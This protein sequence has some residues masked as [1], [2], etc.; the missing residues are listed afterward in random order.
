M[1][2]SHF[3]TFLFIFSIIGGAFVHIDTYASSED[4]LL[5]KLT[6]EDII[7]EA[8]G[9]FSADIDVEYSRTGQTL[10]S[11]YHIDTVIQA[12][13]IKSDDTGKIALNPRDSTEADKEDFG[14][15]QL[16]GDKAYL[17][18]STTDTEYAKLNILDNFAVENYQYLLLENAMS[19]SS[20]AITVKVSFANSLTADIS[21]A[22]QTNNVTL[23]STIYAIRQTLWWNL[24]E[25]TTS[26]YPYVINI[27]ITQVDLYGYYIF[28]FENNR[29]VIDTRY[30]ILYLD[31]DDTPITTLSESINTV[32]H[33][34]ERYVRPHTDDLSLKATVLD[35][36]N[37][38][39]MM[40]V[41][42]PIESTSDMYVRAVGWTR[43]DDLEDDLKEAWRQQLNLP[44]DAR[45]V[46]YNLTKGY[47]QWILNWGLVK[48]LKRELQE[49]M[50][51]SS[52]YVT[53]VN[54]ALRKILPLCAVA[55][56]EDAFDAVKLFVSGYETRG[57]WDT[58]KSTVKSTT[59]AVATVAKK[60]VDLPVKTI[61]A[62]G[63][64]AAKVVTPVAQTV[65]SVTPHVTNMIKD[66]V[67]HITNGV[68]GVAGAA[69]DLGKGIMD[70]LK[71]P[72]MIVAG[73]AGVGIVI[74]L[75]IRFGP[76]LKK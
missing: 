28:R 63:N 39:K 6:P 5:A 60:V 25:E 55:N 19:I 47:I 33:N 37:E 75:I 51:F 27:E 73:V 3:F 2:K 69:K 38:T 21:N 72:L 26:A 42:T 52:D 18:K 48:L 67:G 15:P 74:F 8:L 29:Y 23:T 22:T 4:E 54:N 24:A 65:Q 10:R 43:A 68:V 59:S 44:E 46:G 53:L 20:N 62:L 58:I 36:L 11:T 66:N 30:D 64:A 31:T 35:N 14:I 70:S 1:N 45:I 41:Q 34:Y 49:Q 7:P 17:V 56:D 71:V 57:F 13:V 76:M 9:I 40:S 61:D 50:E 12:P 16:A 32:E